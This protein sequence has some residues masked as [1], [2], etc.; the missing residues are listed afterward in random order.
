MVPF[1]IFAK[2]STS[3]LN[4]LFFAPM[5]ISFTSRLPNFSIIVR[6]SAKDLA[7]MIRTVTSVDKWNSNVVSEQLNGLVLYKTCHD[8]IYISAYILNL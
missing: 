6:A 4:T 7:W 1:F 8:D 5:Y 2:N 3:E